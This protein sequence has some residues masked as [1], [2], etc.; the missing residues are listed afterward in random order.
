MK[1]YVILISYKDGKPFYEEDRFCAFQCKDDESSFIQISCDKA[2]VEKRLK[3]EYK[4]L[5]SE[6]YNYEI[7]EVT[8]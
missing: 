7:A 4:S 6:I 1:A 5:Q 2:F 8:L 3:E